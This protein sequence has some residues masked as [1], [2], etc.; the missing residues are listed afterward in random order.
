LVRSVFAHEIPFDGDAGAWPQ[1]SRIMRQTGFFIG[2][3]RSKGAHTIHAWTKKIHRFRM[4]SQRV[5]QGSSRGFRP[6]V[7]ET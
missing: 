2:V 5:N 7:F 4:E 1:P 6:S 3:L